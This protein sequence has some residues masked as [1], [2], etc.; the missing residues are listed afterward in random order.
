MVMQ[1]VR[2]WCLLVLVLLELIVLLHTNLRRWEKCRDLSL[3][4]RFKMLPSALLVLDFRA[5]GFRPS[6][7]D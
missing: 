7:L 4:L 3:L 6:T 2:V 5:S 1:V